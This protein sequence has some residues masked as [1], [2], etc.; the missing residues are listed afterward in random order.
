MQIQMAYRSAVYF[1]IGTIGTNGTNRQ[2]VYAWPL[3]V[4]I[5]SLEMVYQSTNYFSIGIDSY[6]WYQ[7]HQSKSLLWW[8][9]IIYQWYDWWACFDDWY[10]FVYI[11]HV[12]E[13]RQVISRLKNNKAPGVDNIGAEILKASP[14]IALDQLLNICNQTLDQCKAPSDWKRA[15]LAKIPKKG[16]SSICDNYWRISLLSVPYKVFC[17]MLLMRMQDRVEKKL[18]KNRLPTDEE[19]GQLN[20]FS[21]S[22][23]S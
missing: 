16:D 13:L 11:G 22:G 1:Y 19:E 10:L 8:I 5:C 12:W 4:N 3:V 14:P 15:L 23:I 18:G 20:R 17:R 9:V 7:W 6:Q 21:S 2:V